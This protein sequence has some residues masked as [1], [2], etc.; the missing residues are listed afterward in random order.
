MKAS[1]QSTK[2]QVIKTA[3]LDEI[4]DGTFKPGEKFYSES[5]LKE[6]YSVSSATVIRAIHELVNDGY[7][8]RYQGKGTF[9]SKA[10]RN[11][12]IIFSES[13]NDLKGMQSVKVIQCELENVSDIKEKLGLKDDE[14]YYRIARLKFDSNKPYALQIS[15]IPAHY[16]SSKLTVKNSALSS[17]YEA[18][19]V[20]NG[21][22]MYTMPYRQTICAQTDVEPEVLQHLGL[23]ANQP[24]IMMKRFTNNEQG[25]I[26]EYIE[27]WKRLESFY[28]EI[29][30][31][32]K[33]AG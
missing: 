11:E 14:R 16:F 13:D 30:T 19:K 17:I 20:N 32:D 31:P 1:A 23:G 9:V 10:K 7:L 6:R 26:I 3:L 25:Q 5:E 8:I 27:T 24:V 28:I 21:L 33:G 15:H 18:F 12:S 22:D 29:R 4:K 2:Y